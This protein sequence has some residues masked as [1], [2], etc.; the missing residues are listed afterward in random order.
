MINLNKQAMIIVKNKAK[1]LGLTQSDLAKKLG[2]SLPTIKRWYGGGTVT[3]ESFKLLVNEVGLSLTEIFSSI[4]ESTSQTFQYTDE[5]EHFFS[6]NPDYLAYF[7][8][9][10]RGLTPYQIQ[11][12]FHLPEKKTVQYLS[13]IDKLKLIVW[14]PNNKVRLLVNGEPVWKTGGPL[15]TKLRNDIFKSF[16]E[17]ENRNST[18][19]FLHDYLP[20]DREEITRKMQELTELAKRANS[21]AKFKIDN[22]KPMGLYLSLQNFRWEMDKYLS[23]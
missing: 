22:S 12:K 4:E 20:E 1:S 5:Q 23:E 16:I 10:L 19:F 7:D 11:K 3:L 9:L 2:V 21:R 8:N 17:N 15:G 13:K 14:L 6:A 18:H